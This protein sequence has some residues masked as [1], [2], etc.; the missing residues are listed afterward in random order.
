MDFRRSTKRAGVHSP[1]GFPQYSRCVP[2]QTHAYDIKA[3]WK[4]LPPYSNP[5]F[6]TSPHIQ[7][8]NI[9]IFANASLSHL[10]KQGQGFALTW[11][12]GHTGE[13]NNI[14]WTMICKINNEVM[15]TGT[16][17]TKTAAKEEAAKQTLVKLGLLSE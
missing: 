3:V 4:Q 16:A 17:P 2:E 12:E 15:G 7:D 6:F 1:N 5:R 11:G 8:D 9:A 10:Q 14:Q 13:G